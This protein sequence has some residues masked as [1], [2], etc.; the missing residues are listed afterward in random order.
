MKKS[1][2]ALEGAVRNLI[3]FP[4]VMSLESAS[5]GAEDY[6]FEYEK[7]WSVKLNSCEL[8]SHL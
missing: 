3:K 5:G 2:V 4:R 6:T 7:I 8:I 1:C